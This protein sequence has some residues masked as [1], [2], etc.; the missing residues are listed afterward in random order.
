MFR[1]VLVDES[2]LVVLFDNLIKVG[3]ISVPYYLIDSFV[4]Y[5]KKRNTP[6]YGGI[7]YGHYQYFYTESI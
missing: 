6:I 4:E 7:M 3:S 2:P 5:C 1:I